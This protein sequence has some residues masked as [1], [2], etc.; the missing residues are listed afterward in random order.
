MA[1]DAGHRFH[2][3]KTE[4]MTAELVDELCVFRHR[5]LPKG[6]CQA[7]GQSTSPELNRTVVGQARQ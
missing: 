4:L 6:S 5:H 3:G 7:I 2:R 1:G